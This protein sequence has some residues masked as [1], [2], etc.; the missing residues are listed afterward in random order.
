MSNAT[1]TQTRQHMLNAKERERG[2]KRTREKDYSLGLE[3]DKKFAIQILPM[4]MDGSF[5]RNFRMLGRM[6]R[7]L[8]TT[9]T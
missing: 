5:S 9:T 1:K 2:S 3:L 6:P 7:L 8:I 4:R